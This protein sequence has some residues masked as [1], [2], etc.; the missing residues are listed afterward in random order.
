MRVSARTS[1]RQLSVF[2]VSIFSSV[3]F[4]VDYSFGASFPTSSTGDCFHF[5]RPGFSRGQQQRRSSISVPNN[6]R[7]V[8]AT[9]KTEKWKNPKER[10]WC[11]ACPRP[12]FVSYFLGS[13]RL[14]N[15]LPK[16]RRRLNASSRDIF[17]LTV[18][19]C[20]SSPSK[21]ED[22]ISS[23][24]RAVSTSTTRFLPPVNY[25][26]GGHEK[27]PNGDRDPRGRGGRQR[28]HQ[29]VYV[30]ARARASLGGG[31]RGAIRRWRRLR[32][33]HKQYS[34]RIGHAGR[35]NLGPFPPRLLRAKP[36]CRTFSRRF[37]D[38]RGLFRTLRTLKGRTEAILKYC[39]TLPPSQ[40]G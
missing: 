3:P 7:L 18:Q 16:R 5:S 22:P 39:P 25:V 11:P 21:P 35:Y 9:P 12:M 34:Q 27:R 28:R 38:V 14:S 2:F 29:R 13:P 15:N 19:C 17:R 6:C 32:V 23:P 33:G 30:P 4:S 26:I 36:T 8:Y 40:D 31:Q 24:K 10:V 1:S 20:D 37:W